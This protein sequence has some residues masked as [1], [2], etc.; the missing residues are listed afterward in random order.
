MTQPLDKPLQPPGFAG[1]L[2]D[3][4]LGSQGTR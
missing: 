1:R 2:T 4:A 3:N